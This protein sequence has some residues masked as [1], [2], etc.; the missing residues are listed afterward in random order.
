VPG[1]LVVAARLVGALLGYLAVLDGLLLA[2]YALGQTV[3]PER[4]RGPFGLVALG[5]AEGAALGA[6]LLLWRVLDDRPIRALGLRPEGMVGRCLRGAGVAALM[7]GFVVLVGYTLVDGATWDVNPDPATAGL[8]LL[9]G[10]IGFCIQGPAEEV[11]FRG[12]I[13]ENARRAWGLRWGVV[14]S[15][16]SFA[17]VHVANPSFGWL[18]LVNLLL[19]GLATALYK[20]YLDDGQLW[21]VFAI[22]AVWNWLQQVVF[23]LPNSGLTGVPSQRLFTVAPN[24]QVPAALWGG[25]FGPEG[26][27][28]ATL[29]LL[30]L[31]VALLR[32][33]PAG[34]AA[35]GGLTASS[36]RRATSG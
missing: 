34:L 8:A 2:T 6:V 5:L 23:G 15:S 4:A 11:L 22:H 18:P 1:G 19:F 21:G 32:R 36:R 25:G 35:S 28:A 33:R 10:L 14:V 24:T 17:A 27:L 30:G 3:V 29:V 13:L 20:R 26:T 9:G 16:L 31:I 12:Y 7:M